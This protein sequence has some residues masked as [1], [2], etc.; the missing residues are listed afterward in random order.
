MRCLNHVAIESV[1]L[2]VTNAFGFV[3]WQD[4]KYPYSAGDK[5]IQRRMLAARTAAVR[6]LVERGHSHEEIADCVGWSLSSVDKWSADKAGIAKHYR[7]IFRSL[8]GP[9]KRAA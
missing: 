1:F 3:K 9:S 5:P 4:W 8:P 7:S 2:S 6:M